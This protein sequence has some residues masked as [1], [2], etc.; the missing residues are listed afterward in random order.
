[1][2]RS[3]LAIYLLVAIAVAVAVAVEVPS[4]VAEGLSR[5]PA[6]EVAELGERERVVVRAGMGG[7][8]I[9]GLLAD[10]G[11]IND[12]RRFR[13]LVGMTGASA[14]LQAG[15]YEI[16]RGTPSIEVLR[17][18]RAGLTTDR[19][20]VIPEGL[21]PEEVADRAVREGVGSAADWASA[22]RLAEGAPGPLGRPPSAGLVGFLF[23]AAY[24]IECDTTP[25]TLLREMLETFREEVPATLLAEGQSEGL[26]TTEILTLASIIEREAVVKEE[27]AVI[28]S[29]YRNRLE[30]GMGLDA[31]PTVQ[32]AVAAPDSAARYGW[33]KQELT[34][35]DLASRS[36]YNT[37]VHEGLPP[38][39][40]ASPGLEAI[41]AA[42]HPADTDFLY[43]VARGD[44]G[45]AF[46]RTLAE[47]N[48]NVA[49]YLRP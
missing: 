32:Y 48:S 44:G 46:A 18:L 9:A 45:H 40:I 43:F 13:A 20:L 11:V 29:V 33:W 36:P 5:S 16:A 2:R 21:R 30:E 34:V 49:Q 14:E 39:P 17:R 47:H 38:G 35:D 8:D 19:V 4:R 31:D 3:F 24:P 42:V 28:A 22:L 6:V 27:R 26:S 25:D 23:P 41:E 12:A 1:M 10:Q 37:Y 7:D 15:C